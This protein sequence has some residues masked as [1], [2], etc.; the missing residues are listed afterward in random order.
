MET[1]TKKP[2]KY[3]SIKRKFLAFFIFIII[4]CGVVLWG[5]FSFPYSKGNRAG[6]LYKFSNK[7]YLFKTYEGEL[8][9]GGVNPLPGNTIVNNF[10]QF[11]VKDD[12]VASQLMELEGKVVR[13]HYIEYL[14]NLPWRG[15][16]KYIVDEIKVVDK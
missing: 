6:L 7:G 9:L 15:D 11:S 8:N 13:L 14:G 1:L 16:T 12:G 4:I 10:W 5:Y 2:D 3:K